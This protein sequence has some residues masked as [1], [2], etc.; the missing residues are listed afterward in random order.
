[1]K[2]FGGMEGLEGLEGFQLLG[3]E[4]IDDVENEEESPQYFNDADL[5]PFVATAQ[6]E[7]KR[8]RFVSA[9]DGSEPGGKRV[10]VRLEGPVAERMA[11]ANAAYFAGDVDA[12]WSSCKDLLRHQANAYDPY[13]LMSLIAEDRGESANV[14]CELKF[15][16]CHFG[17]PSVSVCLSAAR[18]ATSLGQSERVIDCYRFALQLEPNNVPLR[19]ELVELLM[20]AGRDEEAILH[21]YILWEK[22]PHNGTVAEKLAWM[23]LQQSETEFGLSLLRGGPSEPSQLFLE[24][25]VLL[26]MQADCLCEALSFAQTNRLNALLAAVLVARGEQKQGLE[27]WKQIENP[28]LDAR[29]AMAQY[30]LFE[31][32]GFA[33]E[34]LS[35]IIRDTEEQCWNDRQMAEILVMALDVA[36]GGN[37]VEAVREL[38]DH[39]ILRNGMHLV[40][41]LCA[42]QSD[43]KATLL[44]LKG[45]QLSLS[46]SGAEVEDEEGNADDGDDEVKPDERSA[47]VGG[48]RHQLPDFIPQGPPLPSVSRSDAA[49]VY[50]RILLLFSEKRF[51]ELVQ[52]SASVL[53][54]DQSRRLLQKLS[55][56]ETQKARSSMQKANDAA[57]L[58]NALREAKFVRLYEMVLRALTSLGNYV[59]F[60]HYMRELLSMSLIRGTTCFTSFA[61]GLGW[62]F[63]DKDNDLALVSLR[64]LL[65]GPKGNTQFLWNV[66][67]RLT[68]GK[69]DAF[70]KHGSELVKTMDTRHGEITN[71]IMMA[72]VFLLKRKWEQAAS[73]YLI[74]FEKS[75]EKENLVA[76]FGLAVALLSDTEGSAE[77]CNAKRLRGMALILKWYELSG[78]TPSAAY[79]VARV[80]QE[81][82]MLSAA[83]RFYRLA[84]G[85]ASEFRL[86]AIVNL[87]R[88]YLDVN[89]PEAAADLF[90]QFVFF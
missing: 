27:L 81:L 36:D 68:T 74:C 29:M 69:P 28:S 9:M 12:A 90:N 86:E 82:S 15:L 24:R 14:I 23:S 3:E 73:L 64:R 87:R 39:R 40:L 57:T 56:N 7:R 44:L 46:E 61:F 22:D 2:S 50:D 41:Q 32:P 72:H 60:S 59:D 18:A 26:L 67:C 75:A 45:L 21:L 43:A 37:A 78:K 6:R 38:L 54:R 53:Q 30:Q 89:N 4:D 79:N 52:F 8:P 80:C 51:A 71:R 19:R 31:N 84:L 83:E 70:L 25:H 85:G 16:A 47:A 20:Q 62:P 66:W 65:K 35:D 13:L 17:Q 34:L 42:S 55:G 48:W 77:I 11:Q 58:Y 76:L 33:K 1:M 10:A 5:E 88:L 63:F 49:R